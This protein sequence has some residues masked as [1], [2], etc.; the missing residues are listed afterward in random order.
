MEDPCEGPGDRQCEL[1]ALRAG[2]KQEA[3]GDVNEWL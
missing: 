1:A 3:E 2:R